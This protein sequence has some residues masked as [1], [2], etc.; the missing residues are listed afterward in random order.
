M[1]GAIADTHALIWYLLDSP[2]LSAP[3]SARFETCRTEGAAADFE[4]RQVIK[5]ARCKFQRNRSWL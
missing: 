2:R 5:P 4:G 1:P 3:A